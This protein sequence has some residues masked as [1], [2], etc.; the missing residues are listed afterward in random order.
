MEI[1][2]GYVPRYAT[3]GSRSWRSFMDN[4]VLA[5]DSDKQNVVSD[6]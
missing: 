2:H 5:Y 1:I 6:L 3:Q 4:G